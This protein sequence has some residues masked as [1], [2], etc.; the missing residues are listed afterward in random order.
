M[1]LCEMV[2]MISASRAYQTDVDV[3][4]AAKTLLEKALTI[5]L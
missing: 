4:N 2:N 1:W 3:M 5:G